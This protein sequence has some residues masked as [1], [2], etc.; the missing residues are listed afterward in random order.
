MWEGENMLGDVP[1]VRGTVVGARKAGETEFGWPAW[2]QRR[3]LRQRRY[4]GG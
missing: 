2:N 4:V 1:W 3:P